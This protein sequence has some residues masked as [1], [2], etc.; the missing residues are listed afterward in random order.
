MLHYPPESIRSSTL[1]KALGNENNKDEEF[2]VVDGERK[3]RIAKNLEGVLFFM[4]DQ[5]NKGACCLEPN[6][7]WPIKVNF[8]ISPHV[9]EVDDIMDSPLLT[10]GFYTGAVELQKKFGTPSFTDEFI[11]AERLFLNSDFVPNIKLPNDV[12]REDIRREIEIKNLRRANECYKN[13]IT[14]LESLKEKANQNYSK[15][16]MKFYQQQNLSEYIET[17]D[18]IIDIFKNK[19][20]VKTY[21]SAQKN[22]ENLKGFTNQIIEAYK[23][24]DGSLYNIIN[25]PEILDKRKEI[26]KHIKNNILTN[27]SD[28]TIKDGIVEVLMDEK[29]RTMLLSEPD[30]PDL[31]A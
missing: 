6:P 27:I 29:I 18:E 4:N 30:N 12:R 2:L 13:V 9:I 14:N 3:P 8:N 17:K 21:F 15:D 23:E 28:N 22:I 31:K 16:F 19:N 7:L 1:D 10:G 11:Y 26:G 5:R 20:E 24:P 25:N